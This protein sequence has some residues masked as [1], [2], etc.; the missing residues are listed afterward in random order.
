MVL[1]LGVSATDLSLG[2]AASGRLLE[3]CRQFILPQLSVASL[4]AF[5]LG[6]M[7]FAALALAVRSAGRQIRAQHRFR[8][9]LTVLGPL[10]VRSRPPLVFA[11]ASPQA[12]CA[13]LLRPRIYVSDAAVA[14]LG[15]QELEAVLAHEAHH[16]RYRDPLRIFFARLL[17]DSLF[18]L[19]VLSRL[20]DRYAALA[21]VAADASAVRGS[22]GDPRPLAAALLTFG[23]APD[24]AV[25]GIAPERVDHL[26]GKPPRWELPL[27]LLAWAVVV[28]G[29]LMVVLL[30]TA[31][32]GTATVDLPML[33]HSVCMLAMALVP[34]FLGAVA[35]L[36][37]RR[38]RAPQR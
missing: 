14:V 23:Q 36:R 27:A 22:D 32:A 17:S 13:G 25:V 16:A 2:S 8:A 35:L 29:A 4:T 31:E 26:L 18:F 37:L 7:A 5:L 28:S 33:S 9:G 30:R 11:D 38:L 19:P 3:A 15:D 21:E 1:A 10:P 34:L 12:F 20:A 6:S 24:S